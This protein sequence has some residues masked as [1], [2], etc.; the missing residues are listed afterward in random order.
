MTG[1]V[2]AADRYVLH[3][4]AEHPDAKVTFEPECLWCDWQAK[5]STDPEP[6]DVEC[7]SHT[8]RSGH[9]SFRRLRTSFAMVVRAE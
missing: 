5:P 6:V 8:G 7:M 1:G 2:R 3:Q 4:I 9:K